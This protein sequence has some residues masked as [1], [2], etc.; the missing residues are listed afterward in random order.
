L[1]FTGASANL[2]GFGPLAQSSSFVHV[3]SFFGNSLIQVGPGDF[4]F[5]T[6]RQVITVLGSNLG[7]RTYDR[8]FY[9]YETTVR[10]PPS[11]PEPGVLA[12]MMGGLSLVGFATRRR[13][14]GSPA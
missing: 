9:Y 4:S 2:Q 1:S 8:A 12:L 10:P 13:R 14:S 5:V 6:A 7:S 3:G 11:V